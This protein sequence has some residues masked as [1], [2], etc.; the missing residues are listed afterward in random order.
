MTEP[1]KT[2]MEL[3]EALVENMTF[4]R[5]EGTTTTLCIVTLQ[6]GF[7]VVGKSACAA[8]PQKFSAVLG[9]KF[10]REDAMRQAVEHVVFWLVMSAAAVKREEVV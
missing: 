9:E 10:A 1:T 2:P 4:Q 6:G 8:T 5:V 3:T 7:V